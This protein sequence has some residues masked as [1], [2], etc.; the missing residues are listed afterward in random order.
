MVSVFHFQFQTILYQDIEADCDLCH[1][2]YVTV[3]NSANGVCF[4]IFAEPEFRFRTCFR[5][6]SKKDSAGELAPLGRPQQ[7]Y[8]QTGLSITL[9]W[10]ANGTSCSRPW[11]SPSQHQFGG[12]LHTIIL[13]NGSLG[14]ASQCPQPSSSVQ[15]SLEISSWACQTCRSSCGTG[16]KKFLVALAKLE[17]DKSRTR[18]FDTSLLN[19]WDNIADHGMHATLLSR[20]LDISL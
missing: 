20:I 5:S 18:D 9:I 2:A 4:S 10:F 8:A 14:W 12:G 15:G 13:S 17:R 7:P 6:C 3:T 11:A 1:S 16:F 19:V